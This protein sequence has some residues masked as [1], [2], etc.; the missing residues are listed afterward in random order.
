ML[1]V[2]CGFAQYLFFTWP[3]ESSRFPSCSI[4]RAAA[5]PL[6]FFCPELGAGGGRFFLPEFRLNCPNVL[7]TALSSPVSAL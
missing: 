7:I 3:R 5:S 6:A 4:N 1:A 2:L